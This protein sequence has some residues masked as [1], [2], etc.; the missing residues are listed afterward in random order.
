MCCKLL[1]WFFYYKIK[2]FFGQFI[3]CR[4][5]N[6]NEY[7]CYIKNTDN[8][9]KYGEDKLLQLFTTIIDNMC[10]SACM[11]YYSEHDIRNQILKT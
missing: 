10:V 11:R 1:V 2:T 7:Q 6:K 8:H 9:I 4:N 5:K 3:H